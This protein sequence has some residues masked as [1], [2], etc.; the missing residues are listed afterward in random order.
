MKF[1]KDRAGHDRRYAINCDKIKNELGWQRKYDF[2]TAIELTIG[3]YLN[4]KKWIDNIKSGE[5]K[6]WIELNYSSK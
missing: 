1:V 4:N 2:N 6:K 3:W 5:Y